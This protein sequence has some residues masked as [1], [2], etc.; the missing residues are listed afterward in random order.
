MLSR[1]EPTHKQTSFRVGSQVSGGMPSGGTGRKARN[2][3]T[4]SSKFSTES[5]NVFSASNLAVIMRTKTLE[6][7]NMYEMLLIV[8]N[9]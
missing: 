8:E 6:R 9:K 4:R 1:F 7:L 3:Y 5:I 2:I